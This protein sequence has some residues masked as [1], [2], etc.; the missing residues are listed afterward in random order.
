MK[1]KI[2]MIGSMIILMILL[3]FALFTPEVGAI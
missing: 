2:M 1:R 3:Y